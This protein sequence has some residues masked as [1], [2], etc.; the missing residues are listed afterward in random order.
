MK[1]AP[2]L[3]L[4]LLSFTNCFNGSN[5]LKIENVPIIGRYYYPDEEIQIFLIP[6]PISR[7]N[8]PDP[9]NIGHIKNEKLSIIFPKQ[10][11]NKYLF[12]PI[13]A[14]YTVTKGHKVQIFYTRPYIQLIYKETEETE[15]YNFM[16]SLDY[17]VY[18]N[19]TG[20]ITRDEE[21]IILK[22]GWN[23]YKDIGEKEKINLNELSKQGHLWYYYLLD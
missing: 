11:D 8:K 5:N 2:Y 17:I 1:K 20:K 22:K 21:E 9:I 7:D 15:K 16:C 10:L 4:I 12:D 6:F 23:I 3:L 18:S 14:D 13:E 19:K